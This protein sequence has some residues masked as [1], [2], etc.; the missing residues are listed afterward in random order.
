[1]NTEMYDV[2]K[3]AQMN[4]KESMQSLIDKFMPIILKYEYKL[5]YVEARTDLII[6]FIQLIDKM[7][8][9]KFD[10]EKEGTLVVYINKALFNRSINLFKKN[11]INGKQSSEICIDI[12]PDRGVEDNNFDNFLVR[13]ILS[14]EIITDKQKGILVNRYL[15]D[16][17]DA[18]IAC[19]LKISRQA[20]CENRTRAISKLR[21][22]LNAV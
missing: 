3:L 15:R 22:Y 12:I 9:S 7:D 10:S 2:I 8:L 19:D 6:E 14:K 16:K 11:I 18:E 20:V 1:M 13:E 5:R 4:N 21:E 17:S